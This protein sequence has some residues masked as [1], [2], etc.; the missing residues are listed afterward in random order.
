MIAEHCVWQPQN[1]PQTFFVTC[2]IFE[3]FFGGAR[4]GG[5]T[6]AVLGEWLEHSDEYG[7]AAIG[8]MIRRTRIELQET[9]ERGK[10]IYTPL[11]FKWLDQK[12]SFL[13]PNGSRLRFSY[14]ER[15]ADADAYQG[16][17]Y[18]RLYVEELGNFP[19]PEPIFKL[20]ATLRSGAGVP[21]GFRATG[22][23]GG[24]GHQWVRARYISPAPAG[25]T[26]LLDER[27]GELR[28]YVPSRLADNKFLGKDYV[29]RLKMTGSD[30]LVKAWLE[31]DWNIIDGAYFPEWSTEK[32]VLRPVSLPDYWQRF[33]SMDWGSAS[34]FSVGW[35][36]V[37]T[38]DFK[39]PDGPVI[40]RGAIV[41]YREWYGASAPGKGLKLT[42]EEVGEGIKFREKG[43]NI[44]S[45]VLDPAAFNQDGGPSIAERMATRQVYFNPADNK[46]VARRGAMG[47]WDQVRARLKGDGE[48]PALFVFSSCADFIRT[49]PALQHDP[50]NPEDV[51]TEQEDH[52]P[53]EA[54]YAC[55]SRPYSRPKPEEE[56]HEKRY[57]SWRDRASGS[58]N[59]WQSA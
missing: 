1:G 12:S 5:K 35:W 32:H 28:I 2:P 58:S 57:S 7:R 17:S 50:T 24:P 46:R 22:N 10:E 48:R 26:P 55:M 19:R 29:G 11:G 53:D 38:E 34:P 27:S 51:N 54:R 15:D 59:G 44:I 52:A 30:Q 14:L 42:A 56:K 33:R 25:M 23:P 9:I 6:D 8:L 4:G 49:F 37:A 36:A 45:G 3:V 16:H 43:D 40:P 20:M 47:G 13:G 39:H 18:T 31:G 21:V 41:R